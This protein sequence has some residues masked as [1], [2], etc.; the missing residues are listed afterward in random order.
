M[1][2]S[3]LGGVAIFLIVI[4]SLVTYLANKST[5]HP[6]IQLD[7]DEAGK[8]MSEHTPASLS[9]KNIGY[10]LPNITHPLLVNA[11]G[12]VNSGQVLAIMGPS[13]AGK[14]TLLDILANRTKIGQVT[15]NVYVN[16]RNCSKE[17]YVQLIGYVDQEDTMIPTLT[18]YETIL[19]S[20]LLRLPRSMSNAAKE[21]RVMEVMQELGI[22]GIKDSRIGQS[23]DRS[24]SGGERRRVAIACELVTSPSILFLDEPT[25]GLDAYNAFNVVESLVT[26][27]RNYNRTVIFTIHQPRSNIVTL[28]DRLILLAKGR[29]IYSG[30]QDQAQNYFGTIGYNCPVGFNIADYLIDLTMEAVER[31]TEEPEV[32]IVV[33]NEPASDGLTPHL[34]TLSQ[35]Y[36]TSE[37]S[38][39]LQDDITQVV[40]ESDADNSNSTD[41]N[42]AAIL[43]YKRPGVFTQFVILSKRTFINLYRNPMLMFAHYAIAV[44]LARKY[45]SDISKFYLFTNTTC[46]CLWWFVLSSVKYHCWFPK[47]NGVI[48][49]L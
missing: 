40:S 17:E 49:F 47:Q 19:Y 36:E 41:N 38:K 14:T 13:G 43:T 23:G 39:A 32:N 25:S 29:I 7:D 3:G 48:L 6:T 20:A 9:F 30:S 8:L 46:S 33:E 44:V 10:T 12:Y 26:L 31:D 45:I 1:I 5:S 34:R 16:G 2:A 21:Y 42:T 27:A 22:D 24:I 15:G 4:G 37:V 35:A 28:F 11:S 18:V